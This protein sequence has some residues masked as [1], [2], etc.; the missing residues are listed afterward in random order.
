MAEATTE[1]RYRERNVENPTKKASF[2]V[3]ENE[4]FERPRRDLNPQL[5]D[6]QSDDATFQPEIQSP[7]MASAADVCPTVC[8]TARKLVPESVPN[9]IVRA[10]QEQTSGVHVERLIDTTENTMSANFASAL[11]M[12]ATLP[13]SDAEKADAVRRLLFDSV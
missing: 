8:P 1:R 2:L 3:I 5:P 13:L 10:S 9:S 11:T 12:I 6:R 7:V 4:P